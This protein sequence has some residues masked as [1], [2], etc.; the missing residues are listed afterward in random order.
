MSGN[1]LPGLHG[2]RAIAAIAVIFSHTTVGLQRFG[3]NNRLF[4]VDRFGNIISTDL[5]GF[6][7][8]MF[9]SLSGFLITYLLL[10]EKAAAGSIDI[11]RFYMRRVLRIFPL[12]YLYLGLI[13]LVLNYFQMEINSESFLMYVFLLGNIPFIL[14]TSIDCVG[15]FWSLGVEEQFYLFWPIIIK[16]IRKPLK[17]V[18]VLLI[19][20]L[21]LKLGAR[22]W[23]ILYNGS[24]PSVFYTILHV[25]RFQCMMIGALGGILFIQK[26]PI[27]KI[28]RNPIAEIIVWG[29]LILVT[30]NQFHIAS[31]FDNEF[32]ALLT[33]VLII[34]QISYDGKRVN[35]NKGIFNW[36]GDIS[37]GLYIFHPL[38]LLLASKMI[39]FNGKSKLTDYLIC[40]GIVFLGTILVSYLSYITFERFFLRIKEKRFS[41][42]QKKSK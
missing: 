25:N 14:G 24:R 23:D 39:H 15:H 8:S 20:L 12:Y 29:I 7:V 1:Y 17:W 32:I 16:K 2:I 13:L 30:F 11:K 42:L 21:A 27:L 41:V 33:L 19:F 6:G 5:A 35:L 31:V 38:V 36:L 10:K 22:V 3:L 40:Y 9:F 28:V 4:G 18:F 37:Y 34:Q 26:H